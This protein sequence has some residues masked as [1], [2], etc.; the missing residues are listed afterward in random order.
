MCRLGGVSSRRG[1]DH[2]RVS[3]AGAFCDSYCRTHL[4]WGGSHDEP[5]LLAGCYR[6]CFA[7]AQQHYLKSL[8]FPS[9]STGAYRYPVEKASEIALREI[10]LAISNIRIWKKSLWLAL[11]K[12]RWRFTRKLQALSTVYVDFEWLKNR[13]RSLCN[14]II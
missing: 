5:E 11:I 7:L 10:Q 2:E 13:Y 4:A 1:E 3:F 6:S 12:K 9:I 8:A 14:S